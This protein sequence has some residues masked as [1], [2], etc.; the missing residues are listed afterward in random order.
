MHNAFQKQNVS[1]LK[2]PEVTLISQDIDLNSTEEK[3][4]ADAVKA[5]NVNEMLQLRDF[6]SDFLSKTNMIPN[7][8]AVLKQSK[9]ESNSEKAKAEI[10]FR[11]TFSS[12]EIKTM[13][14]RKTYFNDAEDFPQGVLQSNRDY[15]NGD[16]YLGHT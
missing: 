10:P 5:L 16:C 15:E 13:K 11:D 6:L 9:E 14:K 4:I 2:S 1:R 7:A 12:N 3:A 8:E